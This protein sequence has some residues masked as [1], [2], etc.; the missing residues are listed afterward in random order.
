MVFYNNNEIRAS[1]IIKLSDTIEVGKNTKIAPWVEIGDNV[2]IGT[3]CYIGPFTKIA[4]GVRIGNDTIIASHNNIEKQAIIGNS[5]TLEM[6]GTIGPYSL[7]ENNVFVG[8]HF[9]MADVKIVPMGPHG[10]DPHKE[11]TKTSP[12]RIEENSILGARVTLLPG[13]KIGRDSVID[14]NSLITKNIPQGSHIRGP[15]EIVARMI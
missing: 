15:K 10:T 9:S 14:M 7:I 8:P 6:H 4:N 1:S 12:I 11:S 2:I 3:G 13:I 5:V